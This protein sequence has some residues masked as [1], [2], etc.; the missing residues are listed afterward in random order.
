MDFG[1]ALRTR[2]LAVTAVSAAAGDRVF[3]TRRKQNSALPALVLQSSGGGSEDLD[4]DDEGD[5]AERR[6]QLSA[7][8]GSHAEASEL[9]DAAS[10][11]LIADFE[12]EEFLFWEGEREAPIDL[13]SDQG[14]D[15]FIHEITRDVVLRVSRA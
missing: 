10:L 15:G 7:L 12:V 2:L 3:W 4:L 11:A 9:V 1:E 5:S 8:A 14:P 6:V 13:G